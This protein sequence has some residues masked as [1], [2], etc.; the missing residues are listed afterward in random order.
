MA[1]NQVGEDITANVNL[2]NIPSPNA[3][4]MKFMPRCSAV[5]VHKQNTHIHASKALTSTTYTFTKCREL[6]HLGAYPGFNPAD[7]LLVENTAKEMCSV[8]KYCEWR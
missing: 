6:L 2:T 5:L 4:S 1:R 3:E 8:M 7:N